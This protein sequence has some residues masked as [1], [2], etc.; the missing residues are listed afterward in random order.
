[1]ATRVDFPFVRENFYNANE[2]NSSLQK[3]VTVTKSKC[4]LL[5]TL[6][7]KLQTSLLSTNN[8]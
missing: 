8:L 7:K 5:L 4:C 1:M 6:E 3:I 2:R